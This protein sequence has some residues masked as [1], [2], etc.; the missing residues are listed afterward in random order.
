M[1]PLRQV[2]YEDICNLINDH[3]MKIYKD[4]WFLQMKEGLVFFYLEGPRWQDR[5]KC[6][7]KN[8]RK[9]GYNYT[10]GVIQRKNYRKRIL[11]GSMYY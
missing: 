11:S 7:T 9:R 8:K 4:E 1:N 6:M 2:F 3:L 10:L 5:M